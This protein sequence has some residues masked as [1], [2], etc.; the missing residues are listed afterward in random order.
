[1]KRLIY[2][3]VIVSLVVAI[4]GCT[5]DIWATNKTYSGNGITFTYPG[6]WS[7]SDPNTIDLSSVSNA[8]VVARVGDND[9]S[10]VVTTKVFPQNTNSQLTLQNIKSVSIPGQTKVSDKDINV[11]GTQGIQ[12]DYKVNDKNTPDQYISYV[13]W[14]KNSKGYIIGYGSRNNDTQTLDRIINTIKTT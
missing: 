5:S 12:M 10:F 1:M 9:Y 6:T 13:A 2:I 14:I 7:E 8:T 11:D 3:L 4:S